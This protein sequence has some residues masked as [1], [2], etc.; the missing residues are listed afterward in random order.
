MD[1]SPRVPL[2]IFLFFALFYFATMPGRLQISDSVYSVKT[3]QALV[4][5]GTLAL[6]VTPAAEGYVFRREGQAFSKFG[7]GLA[8]IWTPLVAVAEVVADLAGLAELPRD[9]LTHSIVSIYSIFFG[10][11]GCVVF[12][13]LA[14]NFGAG[15]APGVLLTLAFGSGTILW[16][17]GVYDFSEIV[18]SLF[19]MGATYAAWRN[20]PYGTFRGLN[21]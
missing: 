18:Q 8:L 1:A 21:L 14:R 9:I 20:T 4:R 16:K 7:V 11:A 3:A 5:R 17:Y 19:L 2:W 13:L 10:A 15:P 12:Y 6:E